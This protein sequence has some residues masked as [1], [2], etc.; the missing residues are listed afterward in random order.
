MNEKE[1]LDYRYEGNDPAVSEH[2]EKKI[3]LYL[4]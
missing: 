3:Q 2:I 4:L 1:F